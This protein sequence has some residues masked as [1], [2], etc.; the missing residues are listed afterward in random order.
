M[1]QINIR[2]HERG[3]IRLFAL[4]LSET[5]A[6]AL[7]SKDPGSDTLDPEAV[8]LQKEA[9][10]V[11]ELDGT[12]VE[13]FPVAD[14]EE[15]GL[16]GYM[17]EGNGVDPDEIEPDRVKLAALDGWIMIVY[18]RAFRGKATVLRPAQALTLVATYNDPATEWT[19]ETAIETASA[20]TSPV[21]SPPSD[22]AMMGRVAMIALLVLFA[23]TGLIVWIA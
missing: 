19:S 21:K 14:L 4:S 5:E 6:K 12:C 1:Q 7:R 17:I 2:A 22:G 16:A 13:V 20:K 9:L 10:G 15:L 3:V 18:S 11:T 23:L 8:A